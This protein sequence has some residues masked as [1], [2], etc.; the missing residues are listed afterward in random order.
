MSL[1]LNDTTDTTLSSAVNLSS[2]PFEVLGVSLNIPVVAGD[3]CEV[4][5]VTPTWVTNPTS[6]QISI[7]FFIE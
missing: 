3:Y 5:W 2:N 4:K 7:Q 6:V 1:R